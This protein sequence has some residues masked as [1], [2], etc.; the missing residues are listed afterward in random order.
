[1][2]SSTKKVSEIG[3]NE[4]LE[5]RGGLPRDTGV[6]RPRDDGFPW[7]GSPSQ[8]FPTLV[9]GVLLSLPPPLSDPD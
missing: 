6:A 4:T 1:M 2:A 5:D 9:L 8:G 7:R 3:R